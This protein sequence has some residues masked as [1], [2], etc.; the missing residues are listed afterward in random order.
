[1]VHAASGSAPT[2]D[3]ETTTSA[4]GSADSAAPRPAESALPAP[5]TKP[6]GRA[7][8]ADFVRV[9]LFTF[10]VV[11]HSINAINGGAD[12]IRGANLVGTLCHLTRYG[13]VAVTLYV[14]VLSMQGREMSPWQFWRRRFGLVVGPYLAWTLIYTITD[15][16]IIADNP[17]P[18]ISEMAP[19]LAHDLLVGEGKYQLYFLL[20]SMQ[21]YLFFPLISWLFERGRSRP[22]LMLAG[23]TA[24]QLLVFVVYQYL[25]RPSGHAWDVAYQHLWKTLPMYALFITMGVLAA[26]HREAVDRWLRDHMAT[27]VLVAA[28]CAAFTVAG[29]L[30]ATSPGNVPWKANTA[31]NPV[32]LPWYVGGFVL[33]WLIGL[34]WDDRRA[35]GRPAGGKLVSQATLRAFGVFAVHPLILDVLGRVGFLSG[36]FDWFPHSAILRSII[37][38]VLVLTA[39]LALVDVLLR[40]PFSK[41]LTARP[42]IPLLPKRKKKKKKQDRAVEVGES[43]GAEKESADRVG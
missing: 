8:T 41:W 4:K 38:V 19:R 11:A 1:M 14:L 3:D 40:L 12:E 30:L 7:H 15:H 39:S 2:A 35:A 33:L 16:I 18:P 6:R 9:V 42:R 24:I 36:L 28:G 32:S 25:P 31:W 26:Q 27:V 5:T 21:I 29:Y 22:W 17:F 23:G 43:A 10:V 34:V 13:F 20:I 37:L